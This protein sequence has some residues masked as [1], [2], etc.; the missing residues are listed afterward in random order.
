M[1]WTEHHNAWLAT[2]AAL[3]CCPNYKMSMTVSCIWKDADASWKENWE[4]K[5]VAE[6]SMKYM[7]LSAVVF[8]LPGVVGFLL[9]FVC[10]FACLLVFRFSFCFNVVEPP[11]RKKNCFGEWWCFLGFSRGIERKQVNLIN[12]FISSYRTFELNIR[13]KLFSERTVRNRLPGGWGGGVTIPGGVKGR[14]SYSN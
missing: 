9:L 3:L 4:I 6:R 1:V 14:R 2:R 13:K 10:L 8:Q 11:W 5:P 7:Y 12:H